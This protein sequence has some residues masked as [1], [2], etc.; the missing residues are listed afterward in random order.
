MFQ[1]RSQIV[2][3]E[4]ANSLAKDRDIVK[5]VW[6]VATSRSIQYRMRSVY[7]RVRQMLI[8]RGAPENILPL[9]EELV[10]RDSEQED[11][12]GNQSS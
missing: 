6:E 5:V 3:F 1:L 9:N 8:S 7:L 2:S 11:T 12:T 4:W 10:A